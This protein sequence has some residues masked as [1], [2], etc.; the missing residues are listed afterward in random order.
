MACQVQHANCL[1]VCTQPVR[2]KKTKAAKAKA[3]YADQDEEDRELAMQFLAS[4]GK[5]P[6]CYSVLFC[7]LL[8]QSEVFSMCTSCVRGTI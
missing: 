3:K 1:C 2:G 5:P 8:L 7:G 6:V 4:A